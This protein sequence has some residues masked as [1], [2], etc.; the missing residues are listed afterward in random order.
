MFQGRPSQPGVGVGK[1]EGIRRRIVR[2]RCEFGDAGDAGEPV[3]RLR[4][5]G[6]VRH[7]RRLP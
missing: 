5:Q 2:G 7:P 1:G 3:R 6:Q 4:G